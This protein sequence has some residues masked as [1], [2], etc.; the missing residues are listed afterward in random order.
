VSASQVCA[1][2]VC[3]S[4]AVIKMSEQIGSLLE[5]LPEAADDVLQESLLASPD[6]TA[7]RRRVVSRL[8]PT[9]QR[10]FAPR[11]A[12]NA[13]SDFKEI[14]W[15][16]W[17]KG[18]AGVRVLGLHNLVLVHCLQH[19]VCVAT[20]APCDGADVWAAVAPGEA[21]LMLRL[22]GKSRVVIIDQSGVMRTLNEKTPAG[23]Y[24]VITAE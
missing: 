4:P 12:V 1:L 18:S 20:T 3:L 9:P 24:R 19:A 23:F 14:D 11:V 8:S 7:S 10:P 2:G 22:L 21:A 17:H 16:S 6:M 13:T 5:P 15:P